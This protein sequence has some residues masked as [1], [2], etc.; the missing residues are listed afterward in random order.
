MNSLYDDIVE[1]IYQEQ[2]ERDRP[3]ESP[4]GD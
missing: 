1:R 4:A 3:A 2:D